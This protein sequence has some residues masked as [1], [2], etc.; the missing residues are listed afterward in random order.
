MDCHDEQLT[1]EN[2]DEQMERLLTEL[3]EPLSTD[4]ASL[5]RLA[6]NLQV[7][8]GEKRRLERA[9]E[10]INSRAPTVWANM[11][12]H[13]EAKFSPEEAELIPDEFR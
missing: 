5:A 2:V 9:W 12:M 6:H 3:Q 13:D 8:Y 11:A 1:L 4:K 10:R 7:I